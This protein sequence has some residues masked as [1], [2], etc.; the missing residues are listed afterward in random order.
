MKSCWEPGERPR[1]ECHGRLP[2]VWVR[3]F[4]FWL[5]VGTSGSGKTTLIK[6]LLDA[7]TGIFLPKKSPRTE[8]PMEA[9]GEI[10][11]GYLSYRDWCYSHDVWPGSYETAIVGLD[12]QK[13]EWREWGKRLNIN[14]PTQRELVNCMQELVET[15][16]VTD[17]EAACEIA[18]RTGQKVLVELFPQHALDW[19]HEFPNSKVFL[20]HA[21]PHI[22]ID[23]LQKRGDAGSPI[24]RMRI[25]EAMSTPDLQFPCPVVKLQND[26]PG[27]LRRNV[28]LVMNSK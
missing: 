7:D 25:L 4:P 19:V 13:Q 17:I 18:K 1:L 3:E 20:L 27:D 9:S 10:P 11:S 5:F 2:D 6:A 8:R 23:R 16:P 21:E 24:S 14:P 28:R 15:W 26:T 22:I 12:G